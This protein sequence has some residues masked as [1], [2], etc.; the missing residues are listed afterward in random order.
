MKSTLIRTISIFLLMI[1]MGFVFICSFTVSLADTGDRII[2]VAQIDLSNFFDYNRARPVGGYGYEY[3][4]EISSYTGWKYEYIPTTW[5]NAL[6]MLDKGEIDLLAPAVLSPDLK[7]RFSFSAKEIGLSYSTLCV[8]VENRVTA[9]NDFNSFDGMKVGVIRNSP[10]NDSFDK[11]SEENRFSVEKIYY[12]NMAAIIKA[13]HKRDIDAMLV[14]NLEKRPTERI[15]ARFSPVPYYIVTK[16]GN[17]EILRQLN[18][19]IFKIKENNPYF[20]Y[21]L[22]KKY[23][24]FNESTVPIFTGEEKEYI[25]NSGVLKVVYDPAWA[26][27]EYFDEDSGTFKGINA[28]LLEL[29]GKITG[30]KF[31]YII[32]GSYTEALKKISSYKAD[33]LT[34]IDNDAEWANQHHL[35]LTDSYLSSSIVLVKNIRTSNIDNATFALAK[36]YLA[37][38]EYVKKS[39]PRA[40]IIYYNTPEEC[41]EA[42][43]N[44]KADLTFANSYVADRLLRNP[45]L[46]R[47]SIVETS[48]LNDQLCIGV[49]NKSDPRL[50]SIL[51]KSLHSITADQMNR[52]IFQHTLKEKPEINLEYLIYKKPIYFIIV[53]LFIFLTVIAILVF[54]IKNRNLYNEEIKKVAFLDGVT[55]T[56]NYLKFKLEA[57]ALLKANRSKKYAIV[58]VDI[59]KFSYINDT[60]GYQTGDQILSEVAKTLQEQLSEYERGARLSADNF[61]CLVT[62]ENQEN[63]LKRGHTFQDSCNACL[64]LIN[65]R[66]TVQLTTAVY[67]VKGGE[68]DIPSLVGKA[69]IA[70]KTIG[71]IHKSSIVFYDDKIQEEFLRTKKLESSMVSALQNDE[72]Q[73]YLQPKIDLS[74]KKIVGAEAL[75]RWKHPVEGLIYPQQFISLF[76]S[77]GFILELDFYIY[78]KVCGLLRKWMKE[79]QKIMPISVN[80][81]K[82]HLANEQFAIQLDRLLKK[83]RIPTELF[84][85][86]LTESAFFDDTQEA[87]SLIKKLKDLGFFI[88]I[89]DFGSGYSSLNLLK[90][91]IVDVLKLDKEFFRKDGMT[92]KDKIIVDGIIR[93]ANDLNLKIISEGV[94]TQEQVDFL[95]RS[96]CHMAQGYFFARPM[97]V[98]EF[99]KLI[100][101]E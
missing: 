68:T 8:P 49:S 61:V 9:Y 44:G 47:L 37:A 41:F 29:I 69:D 59:H 74:T 76:E 78:E 15:I 67:L 14:G 43:N 28:D 97:P 58:Y 30:L 21:E 89:D 82:A 23:F 80:V 91:L 12:E 96:G 35:I 66:F 99:E 73:V 2:R 65:S 101:Q 94:E 22:E 33:I 95:I 27:L 4:N 60:F 56:D 83:Y 26:P 54:M 87:V 18:D 85:L 53:L 77:N 11:F 57:A 46:N 52:I 98:E 64:T 50:H 24:K 34:G 19:A 36:D 16:K 79:E 71:D 3:L 81:S 48:N 25:K 93:I 55:G 32:S 86:E 31:S 42:V 92:E 39:R 13:L 84:E 7:N 5:K 10:L 6:D 17:T 20:D 45:K 51:D 1:L 72:F 100:E 62:Y 88:S 40:K 75:V 38:S 70:H 90:D 63:L